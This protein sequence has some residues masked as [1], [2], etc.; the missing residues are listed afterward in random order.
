MP[1]YFAYG[2]NMALAAM[3]LRC[4]AS[5]PLGP[6][7]LAR[8]RFFIMREGYA[9]VAR[10]PRHE[11]WGLLWDLALADMPALDRYEGVGGGLY[12]KA[13]QPVVSETGARRALVYLGRSTAAGRPRAGYME[14]VLAAAGEAGLPAYYLRW[15]ARHLPGTVTSPASG[16]RAL[17]SAL[18]AASAVEER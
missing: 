15:L 8:H 18:G 13:Q 2:S 10:D 14:A 3:R 16:M 5:A 11:V 4:P 1:L 12:T 17:R 9:S 7:R 6:A